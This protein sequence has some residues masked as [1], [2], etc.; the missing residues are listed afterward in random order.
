MPSTIQI[1]Y[2]R[3]YIQHR[4]SMVCYPDD[5]RCLLVHP[6]WG[7]EQLF[8]ADIILTTNVC[9]CD[10]VKN[11]FCSGKQ[12][13]SR[14]PPGLEIK[15]VLI[16]LFHLRASCMY[17]QVFFFSHVT[18]KMFM[19]EYFLL[20]FVLTDFFHSHNRTDNNKVLLNKSRKMVTLSSNVFCPNVE[21]SCH[22]LNFSPIH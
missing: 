19:W 13:F 17:I 22:Q 16:S 5:I 15:T 14:F 7:W 6:E 2:F 12:M 10:K 20:Q 18:T 3:S 11:I 8:P 9:S 4:N 21:L 1:C